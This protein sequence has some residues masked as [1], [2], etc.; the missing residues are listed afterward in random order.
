MFITHKIQKPKIKLSSYNKTTFLKYRNRGDMRQYFIFVR[1]VES[2]NTSYTYLYFLLN[3]LLLLGL[4]IIT[5][6]SHC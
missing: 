5:R 4:I 2:A 6:M 1:R 3:L